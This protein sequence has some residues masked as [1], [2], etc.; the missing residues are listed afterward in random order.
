MVLPF[1]LCRD[2]EAR[3]GGAGEG[4]I[5]ATHEELER[6]EARLAAF[7]TTEAQDARMLEGEGPMPASLWQCAG[8]VPRS[9]E[10]SPELTSL[11]QQHTHLAALEAT[12]LDMPPAMTG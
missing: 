3:T 8:L 5:L 2:A 10:R 1:A 7:S 6:L 12:R 4:G 11:Q 9:R